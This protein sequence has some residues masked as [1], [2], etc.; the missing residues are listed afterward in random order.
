M[1][2]RII[3]IFLKNKTPLRET[4]VLRLLESTATGGGFVR[5]NLTLPAQWVFWGRLQCR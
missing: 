1:N 4:L 5:K 2:A 3:F